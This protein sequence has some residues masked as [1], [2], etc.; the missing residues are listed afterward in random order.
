MII[1][2]IHT[3]KTYK[4]VKHVKL[5]IKARI[6]ICHYIAI[7]ADFNSRNNSLIAKFSTTECYSRFIHINGRPSIMIHIQ[8][9][10]FEILYVFFI[11]ESNAIWLTI[12][13]IQNYDQQR[14]LCKYI[15]D[16]VCQRNINLLFGENSCACCFGVR[17]IVLLWFLSS[18][19]FFLTRVCCCS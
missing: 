10:C 4:T 2:I 5:K 1:R 7:Y 12:E 8:L 9:V 14:Y 6:A 15:F 19:D 3:L 17:Y 11:L 13:F 18:L 16:L